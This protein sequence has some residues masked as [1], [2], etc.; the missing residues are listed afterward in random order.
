MLLVPLFFLA[1]I[2]FAIY[3]LVRR[4]AV[5]VHGEAAVVA[6]PPFWPTSQFGWFSVGAAGVGVLMDALINVVSV[7]FVPIVL[8]PA[9]VAFS[10][11][12]RFVQRDRSIAVLM[13]L[14]VTAI[15]TLFWVLFLA[16]EVFIG[17]D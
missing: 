15:G 4:H 6:R 8:L 2:G 10:A 7:S 16:G 5:D 3:A 12:A 11:V 14:V 1:G 9:S 13:I 17:H